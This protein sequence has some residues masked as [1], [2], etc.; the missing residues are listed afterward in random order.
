METGHL[1]RARPA[2]WLGAAV[3]CVGMLG[4]VGQVEAAK[5][6]KVDICHFD[7]NTGLYTLLSVNGNATQKHLDNHGDS[8]PDTDNGTVNLDGDC[9]I[10]PPVKVFARAFINVDGF[11]GYNSAVD[12]EIARLEDAGFHDGIL[13]PGDVLK[14]GQYPTEFIPCPGNVC[15]NTGNFGVQ[16]HVITQVDVQSSISVQVRTS[17]VARVSF[18]RPDVAERLRIDA[19]G[20]HTNIVDVF[21]ILSVEAIQVQDSMEYDPDTVVNPALRRTSPTDDDFINVILTP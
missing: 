20:S 7:A 9:T 12:I 16:V 8:F 11:P 10:V 14:L 6:P 19:P 5:A 21:D 15:M 4:G 18:D 17:Q 3:M 13:N 2:V 1:K